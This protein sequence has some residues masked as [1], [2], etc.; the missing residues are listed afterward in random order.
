MII[1]SEK[2]EQ[3]YD[4]V[5]D[6]LKAEKAYDEEQRQKEIEQEKKEQRIREAY[7][8]AIKAFDEYQEAIGATNGDVAFAGL[9]F[10]MEWV[11]GKEDKDDERR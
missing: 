3:K 10:I 1:Y 9:D 8:N 4:S 11:L 6:C 7:N 2:T 5:E